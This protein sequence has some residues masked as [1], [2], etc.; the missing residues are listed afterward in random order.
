MSW[1]ILCVHERER[2]RE[3][4]EERKGEGGKEGQR[5]REREGGRGRERE[6]RRRERRESM[7]HVPYVCDGGG[8]VSHAATVT[9]DTLLD[10]QHMQVYNP[11]AQTSLQF[12]CPQ[13]YMKG[14]VILFIC[15]LWLRPF[16]A[17]VCFFINEDFS[18]MELYKSQSVKIQKPRNWLLILRC[19]WSIRRKYGSH[20]VNDV[21]GFWFWL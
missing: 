17:I 20:D 10:P 8:T 5:G 6:G 18:W 2:R 15:L 3:E 19:K 9:W 11:W 14:D 1:L 13:R 4:R 16:T 7:S 12:K 21:V